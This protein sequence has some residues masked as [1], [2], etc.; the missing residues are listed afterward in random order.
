MKRNRLVV[1]ILWVIALALLGALLSNFFHQEEL[2]D[3]RKQSLHGKIDKSSFHRGFI[4]VNDN[5]WISQNTPEVSVVDGQKTGRLI[6]EIYPPYRL[7]K[8]PGDSI[9]L[10]EKDED[11]LYFRVLGEDSINDP[12]FSQLYRRWFKH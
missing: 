10:L 11:S 2:I 12:T 1:P 8:Q 9:I 5:I 6:D 4:K 7:K 3:L